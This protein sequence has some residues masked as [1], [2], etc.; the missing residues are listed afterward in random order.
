MALTSRFLPESHIISAS[1][2]VAADAADS[3]LVIA[4]CSRF[5]VSGERAVY[6][7]FAT[8]VVSTAQLDSSTGLSDPE[9]I[10]N[11]LED[12]PSAFN[13]S[14]VGG[15]RCLG[16]VRVAP[17]AKI[18]TYLVVSAVRHGVFVGLNPGPKEVAKWQR[19]QPCAFGEAERRNQPIGKAH[20]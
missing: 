9:E 14:V 17:K 1:V 16:A 18:I 3:G 12:Y 7:R 19:A 15:C 10:W 4:C 20:D 6:A 13:G 8:I 2:S 11:W 5:S